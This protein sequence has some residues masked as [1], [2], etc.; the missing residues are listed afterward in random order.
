MASA[1]RGRAIQREDMALRMR[2][3]PEEFV[4]MLSQNEQEFRSFVSSFESHPVFEHLMREGAIT[5]VRLH[6]RI[7]REKYEEHMDRA[8]VDWLRESGI[9]A[10]P[11]WER[12]FLAYEAL[13]KVPELA[14]KYSVAPGPLIR[15][16]RYIRAN[17]G[18][19]SGTGWVE[20]L[21]RTSRGSS[22]GSGGDEPGR[23][24]EDTAGGARVDLT[25]IIETT[26]EFV[27]RYKVSEQDFM[28]LVLGGEA[29]PA[30]LAERVGCS[31]LE[32]EEVLEAA[33][34]VYLVQSYEHEPQ[35]GK[36]GLTN[37]A[38]QA[39]DAPLAYVEILD[40][41]PSIQFHQDSVYAQR[42]HIR[43]EIAAQ[44]K[45]L[46]DEDSPTREL[47]SRARL[48]NQRLST[49]SRLIT[50]LCAQQVD[51]LKTGDMRRLKP[52][53]QAELSRQMGEHPSTVSRLIRN[54]TIETPHG[55][56]P[57]LFLCQSKTDVVARLIGDF[58][59]LT[60]QEVVAKLRDEFDCYIA[61]R[62]VAYHRG[63]RLRR[64]KPHKSPRK[65]GEATSETK[66][67][68]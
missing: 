24:V 61:R 4:T 55:K 43:A 26:R 22:G 56:I 33:D 16:L 14:A 19:A 50:S 27:T 64:N 49:L 11:D 65:K 51:Y 25:D 46:A 28:D 21:Q 23:T 5:R 6:G 17:A 8:L 48:I 52:L 58:P 62:T 39:A 54:K 68:S 10:Q 3:P 59:K 12:D 1:M 35:T 36:A 20:E 47:L 42:Y 67:E 44:L 63:K 32:A 57:L 38:A 31:V 13:D 34:R 7:P 53:A 60:D 40:D 15:Y 29:T 18:L 2:R 9:A 30:E 45:K 41:K 37:Q 66:S